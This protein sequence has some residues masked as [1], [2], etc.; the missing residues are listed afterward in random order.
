VQLPPN[1]APGVA[2]W[3]PPERPA[4]PYAAKTVMPD[5]IAARG[6]DPAPPGRTQAD[7][8]EELSHAEITFLHDH[9]DRSPDATRGVF[10]PGME[11]ERR[12]RWKTQAAR[13]Q[14][15]LRCERCQRL[16]K[17]CRTNVIRKGRKMKLGVVAACEWFGNLLAMGNPR[18]CPSASGRDVGHKDVRLRAPCN[19]E[20]PP[21]A[22]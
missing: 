13:D 6:S 11:A 2:L 8:I 20:P 7:R 4:Y 1:C 22:G 18:R 10:Q 12:R 17:G 15:A 9:F 14:I 21:T 19:G 3:L 16:Q 5:R